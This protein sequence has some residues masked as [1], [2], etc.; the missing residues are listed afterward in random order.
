MVNNTYP[1]ESTAELNS[2]DELRDISQVIEESKDTLSQASTAK[3]KKPRGR[4]RKTN[5]TSVDNT[6]AR[7]IEGEVMPN[8]TDLTPILKEVVAM[9]YQIAAKRTGFD[10][11][12][13]D[14][15]EKMLI[16]SSLNT[17]I[18]QFAP[19]V[20]SSPYMTLITCCGL[21]AFTTATKYMMYMDWLEM[22]E[23]IS[24]QNQKA[25]ESEAPMHDFTN[26]FPVQKSDVLSN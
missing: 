7:P 19:S 14:E 10:G 26:P 5:N 17:A 23:R 15:P 2:S 24:K 11:F 9:P 20:A 18:N 3:V 4:P 6:T 16:G 13:L 21:I 1:Q 25:K 12:K 22:K 8:Q